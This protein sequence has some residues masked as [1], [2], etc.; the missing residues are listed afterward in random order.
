MSENQKTV[1]KAAAVTLFTLA[2]AA[3]SV[4]NPAL[5]GEPVQTFRTASAVIEA[6]NVKS[7]AKAIVPS[8]LPSASPLRR[9]PL[10]VT[11][12]ESQTPTLSAESSA[13]TKA[14]PGLTRAQV[15]AEFLKARS[16]GTLLETEA[17]FDVAQTRKV[18]SVVV[19]H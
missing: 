16:E 17:D 2:A 12:E 6:K 11:S 19:P 4:F 8:A 13:K 7:S 5:A 15:Q 3:I 1:V 9:G 14:A 10:E 18:H